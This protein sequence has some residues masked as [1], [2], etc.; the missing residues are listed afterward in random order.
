[1]A[2]YYAGRGVSIEADRILLTASTS[3]AYGF[4]FKL[5][6]DPGDVILVPQPSYPLFEF[7]AELEGVGAQPYPLRYGDA[8][9]E[10]DVDRLAA[11]ITERSRAIVLVHPNNPTGSFVRRHEAD[12]INAL[13]RE[14]GLALIVDEVFGDY[15]MA[16]DPGR[17]DTFADEADLLT[18]TLS[19][20][21]KVLG[22]P[23][24]KL[25]WAV[26]QGPDAE[27]VEALARVELIADTYLSVAAPIQVAL[28]ELMDLRT[29]IQGQI[30]IRT[31]ANLSLL[32][33]RTAS[34][35]KAEVLRCDGGWYAVL[36]VDGDEEELTLALLQRDDV[37][38]HPGYFFDF[39][40]ESYIVLSLLSPEFE[41]GV[42]RLLGRVQG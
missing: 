14:C 22:L 17:A 29:E 41:V 6:A 8:G 35:H 20:L 27:R 28:P 39:A 7:L 32:Q 23:Q 33:E 15:G 12:A 36:E 24:L 21:S 13:A 26:V 4:V 2:R 5:L 42:E 11:A 3:E 25:S 18:F 40:R 38:A 30:R 37:L 10:V 34:V 19:G 9:W 31:Q 16:P 1:M